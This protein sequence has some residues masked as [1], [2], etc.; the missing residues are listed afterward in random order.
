[1]RVT[2]AGFREDVA[3]LDVYRVAQ[4]IGTCFGHGV[5]RVAEF[6][7]VDIDALL[8][9]LLE[10]LEDTLRAVELLRLT[11]QLHPAFTRRHADAE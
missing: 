2:I 4:V 10:L 6:V 8:A 7:F 5:K 9:R 1:M 3:N 11:F